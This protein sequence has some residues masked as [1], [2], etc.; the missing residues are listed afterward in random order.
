MN[1]VI[2]KYYNN[3]NIKK[4]FFF[5]F[6]LLDE[7]KSSLKISLSPFIFYNI[8]STYRVSMASA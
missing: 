8:S 3:S 1:R 2:T 7:M 4:I 6:F 5:F